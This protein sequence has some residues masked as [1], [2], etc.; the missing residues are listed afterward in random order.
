MSTRVASDCKA[1]I[2][3]ELHKG[4]FTIMEITNPMNPVTHKKLDG[5]YKCVDIDG[6]Y[7]TQNVSGSISYGQLFVRKT[8]PDHFQ[9]YMGNMAY[10]LNGSYAGSVEKY[11]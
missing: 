10:Y 1:S 7:N 3:L 11:Y 9:S 4:I 8:A 2:S 5:N 6:R